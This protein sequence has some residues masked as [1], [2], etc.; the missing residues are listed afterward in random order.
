LYHSQEAREYYEK[1]K[2]K[3]PNGVLETLYQRVGA[4]P[5]PLSSAGPKVQAE[6]PQIDDAKTASSSVNPTPENTAKQGEGGVQVPSA[7]DPSPFT[8]FNTSGVSQGPKV[9]GHGSFIQA[10]SFWFDP[11]LYLYIIYI[12]V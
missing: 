1:V 6:S 11:H 10:L 4:A 7:G 12:N 8:I 9:S 3:Y 5:N 2:A